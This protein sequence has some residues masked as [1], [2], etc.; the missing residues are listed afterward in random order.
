MRHCIAIVFDCLARSILAIVLLVPF[1]LAGPL[2][3]AGM[4][5]DS[6]KAVDYVW[7][8]TGTVG[9]N[10][11]NAAGDVLSVQVLLNQLQ[12]NDAMLLDPDGIWGP[13]TASALAK[14]ATSGEL[15][16]AGPAEEASPLIV[17]LRR[18]VAAVPLAERIVRVAKGERL[19]WQDGK[20]Q[21]ADRRVSARVRQYWLA[22][23]LD[24]T[25]QE[26]QTEAFQST[27][28]WSAVWVSWVM[29][30]AGAKD[31]FAYTAAHWAYTAAA[32][33]NRVDKNDNPF[34]AYRPS[35][36]SATPGG[37]VVK[38]RSD[39]TASYDNV[40]LGH[41]TH[42]DIVIGIEWP[43]AGSQD[44]PQVLTIG[45]NVRNSVRLTRFP[46]SR[47]GKM[48][49]EYHFAIIEIDESAPQ[50]GG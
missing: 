32:K 45:G 15:D 39:S 34:K 10:G 44:S 13:K 8:L 7:K 25:E 22:A 47:D 50:V 48:A 20:R 5:A 41:K 19:F 30:R 21:E 1:V 17:E 33:K 16:Y 9:T 14:F 23:N 38:R 4:A 26:I 40:E 2:S 42:G 11:D 46:V 36:R 27:H 35:E 3:A 6:A 31:Q 37:V 29:M 49:T 12:P 24:F 28:P 43:A 18:K